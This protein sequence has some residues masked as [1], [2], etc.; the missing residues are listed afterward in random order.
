MRPPL[1]RGP[2]GR[3]RPMGSPCIYL[4][5]NG[6]RRDWPDPGGLSAI[7]AAGGPSG[8]SARATDPASDRNRTFDF[9]S[10]GS[11][12]TCIGA[13]RGARP[14][15]RGLQARAFNSRT[16][17]C[18]SIS[19]GGG[20]AVLSAPGGGTTLVFQDSCTRGQGHA[21]RR[22]TAAIHFAGRGAGSVTQFALVDPQSAKNDCRVCFFPLSRR[23]GRSGPANTE[24]DRD[25]WA[26]ATTA[27]T[28]A[29]RG[30]KNA[31]NPPGFASGPLSPLGQ[32]GWKGRVRRRWFPQLDSKTVQE[33][34]AWWIF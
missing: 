5:T 21:S 9:R 32:E 17:S 26:C 30:W 7:R 24:L 15:I 28:P 34:N 4:A 14:E 22:R 10:S 8:A 18:W 29:Y 20:R 12:L 23:R 19:R 3:G 13:R 31:R 6:W 1:R 25:F 27:S 16:P 11:E 33:M 2:A